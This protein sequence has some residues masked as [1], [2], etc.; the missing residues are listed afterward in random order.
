MK[1][2]KIVTNIFFTIFVLIVCF[3]AVL[4]FFSDPQRDGIF[5]YRGY[6][7][8][9]GSMEPTLHIGD[10]I[11]VK[12]KPYNQVKPKDIISFSQENI[13][14]T[15]RVV[16]REG[17]LLKTRGDNNKISDFVQV[18]A[19]NYVGTYQFKLSRFGKLLMWLQDPMIYSIIMAVIALRIAILLILK[20]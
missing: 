18:S 2:L 14:I 5:G 6:T 7:V 8:I 19:E 11:I 12:D 13:L 1:Y 9:S 16:S 20:K 17:D 3:V 4:N 15:H 10:Y